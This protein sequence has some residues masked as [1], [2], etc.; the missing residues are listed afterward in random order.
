MPGH[1]LQLRILR[2][3]DHASVQ[4]LFARQ[5]WPLRSRA[6]WDWALIDAPGRQATGAP[7]GWV[8]EAGDT[9]VGFLGNLPQRAWQGGLPRHIA[10]CSALLVDV[11]WRGQGA[12]LLRAFSTQAAMPLLYSATANPF[13]APLYRLF[14]YLPQQAAGLD[15]ARRWVADGGAFVDQ[16][17]QHQA[18][19]VGLVWRRRLMPQRGVS[20]WLR[21]VL[22]CAGWPPA[23]TVSRDSVHRC[24]VQRWQPPARGAPAGAEAE[25]VAVAWPAWWSRLC[26]SVPDLLTDRQPATVAWRLADPDL[27]E[28]PAVWLLHDPA[29]AMLGLA[30]AR[31]V[32]PG[33]PAAPRAE[34]MDWCVLP[35]TPAAA[36]AMLLAAVADWAA[37]RG[38][39]FV[40][41]KRF[42]GAAGAQLAA[43]GGRTVA[44][45]AEANWYLL[46]PDAAA[47][48][49]SCWGMTGIDSDD[50]FCSHRH[51]LGADAARASRGAVSAATTRR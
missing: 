8:L 16:A 6:G 31:A 4:A 12:A 1:R 44:L 7:P 9:V 43:L 18:G 49:P 23:P 26:A 21:P 20:R 47:V 5:G 51:D 10:T 27:A 15:L 48:D 38:L 41:A 50:W 30:M 19:R 36:Q 45:P 28:P 11:D 33:A 29:D 39:P 3:D 42:S 22:A 32:V 35:G 13:S 40:E 37:E 17:L 34:L 14:R 46:R 2:A 25:A 24:R